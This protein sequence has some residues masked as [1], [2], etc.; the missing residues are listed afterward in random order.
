MTRQTT[1]SMPLARYAA[2]TLALLP[3][4]VL[5]AQP[6]E[7]VEANEIIVTG[8]RDGEKT[9]HDFIDT[10]TIETSDQMA[11][12][13]AD[14]CPAGFGLPAAYNDIVISRIREVAKQ[15]DIP[16]AAPD[17][18]PNLVV[19]IA[20][21]G[22]EFFDAFRKDRPTLF[23]AL[24]LSEIRD[25]RKSEGPVRAWQ[26]VEL[27]GSDGR[28]PRRIGFISIPGDPPRHV[29]NGHEL[30]G[31][32]PSRI[33]KSTRRDLAISFVVFDLAATEGLTL[34][35]IADHA[36]MRALARTKGASL[37]APTI[38]ALFEEG[39]Y[40]ADGLTTWDAAYLKS[41]YATSNTVSASQQQSNMARLIGE[42]LK[43]PA[44][45][46]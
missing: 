16:V 32:L 20:D 14:V 15:A 44:S 36:A 41:L 23:H 35:Q 5:E 46:D 31:V 34:T 21:D 45:A 11:T 19:I 42:Q 22:R 29:V 12:F 2:M 7:T 9:I 39:G 17:C 24:E 38:L 8:E 30:T 3:V 26:I 6:P 40:R 13:R 28:K 27:R 18:D 1:R 25:V 37:A 4:A 43:G 33:L 10:V